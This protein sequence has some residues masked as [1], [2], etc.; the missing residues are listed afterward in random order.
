M[1]TGFKAHS[2]KELAEL[3]AGNFWF[4]VRNQLIL[5]SISKHIQGLESFLEIG[6]GTGFVISCIAKRFPKARLIGSEYFEEGLLYARQRV[7]TAELYTNGCPLH[8][9]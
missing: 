5:W 2:F 9:L 1:N 4:R 7:P 8:S 3:E 6:C